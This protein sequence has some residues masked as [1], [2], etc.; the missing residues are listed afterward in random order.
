MGKLRR[1]EFRPADAFMPFV[2]GRYVRDGS[3]LWVNRGFGVTGP[4]SRILAA[5]EV[6][7]IVI[8]AA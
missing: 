7:K 5:P 3:T 6:T 4:P 8:V 1:T 2:A